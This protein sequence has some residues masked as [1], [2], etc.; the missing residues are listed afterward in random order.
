MP[1]RVL[2]RGGGDLGSGVA[3]RLHRAG[4]FVLITELPQPLV[5]RR[6]VAFAEAIYSQVARVEEALARHVKTPDEAWESLHRGEVPVI[7]DPAAESR[8]WFRPHVLVDARLTK[9]G[10]DLEHPA[11]MLVIGIGPGFVAGKD[12]H[13]VIESQ[14]GPTLGRVYWQGSTEPDSGVP[15]SVLGYDVQRVLRAP[16]DGILISRASI[17]DLVVKDQVI[18]EVDSVEVRAP[19][20]GVIRGLV[21]DGL[22]VTKGMK[23]GDIDPRRNP[24]LC[25]LVSEKSLAM[26]GAA[27]EAILSMPA[28][29]PLLYADERIS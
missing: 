19:F 12:C 2:I 25:Y 16:A 9:R 14:R 8:A 28:L 3:I 24:K 10:S 17:G 5:V 1:L 18:A 20:D 26:G 21:A 11:A 29:R 13:A 6:K 22:A 27:L 4:F 15:E 7:I 23:I